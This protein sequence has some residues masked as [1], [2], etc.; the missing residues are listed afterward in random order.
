MGRNAERCIPEE[1]VDSEVQ[2]ESPQRATNLWI[3]F[4][5]HK[6]YNHRATELFMAVAVSFK[7]LE[8][9]RHYFPLEVKK[10]KK[11]THYLEPLSDD[12]LPLIVWMCSGKLPFLF[13]FV[14]RQQYRKLDVN[15]KLSKLTAYWILTSCIQ[16][17]RISFSPSLW[18]SLSAFWLYNPFSFWFLGQIQ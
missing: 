18:L 7:F 3:F 12:R 17:G 4:I 16:K 13:F 8:R 11:L 9:S 6:C 1:L 5:Q 2:Y 10:K 15:T 14:N